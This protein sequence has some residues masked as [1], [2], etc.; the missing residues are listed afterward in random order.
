MSYVIATTKTVSTA[1]V[2]E[3]LKN[4]SDQDDSMLS[5]LAFINI[6]TVNAIG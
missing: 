4:K 2:I 6:Q 5:M 1:F 3:L